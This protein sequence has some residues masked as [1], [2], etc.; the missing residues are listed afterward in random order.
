[1]ESQNKIYL[2]APECRVHHTFSLQSG[3]QT[4][5]SDECVMPLEKRSPEGAVSE[6]VNSPTST[7]GSV[8][9]GA[10]FH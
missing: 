4:C 2:S 10:R 8:R 5:L 1:M 3:L 9:Y 7:R 6:G